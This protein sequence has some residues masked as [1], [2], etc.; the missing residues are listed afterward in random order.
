[1][2]PSKRKVSTTT[3]TAQDIAEKAKDQATNEDRPITSK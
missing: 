1:M 3:K 2:E